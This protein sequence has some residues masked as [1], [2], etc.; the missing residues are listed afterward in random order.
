LCL[1]TALYIQS[2]EDWLSLSVNDLYANGGAYLYTKYGSIKRLVA[3]TYPEYGI[4][5]K[6]QPANRIPKGYW[7]DVSNQRKT[8]EQL[9]ESLSIFRH[10]ICSLH[11]QILKIHLTGMVS[12]LDKLEN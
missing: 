3:A 4:Q 2:K 10:P 9:K 11:Q 6:E 8:F 1:I 7:K 12:R 5:L